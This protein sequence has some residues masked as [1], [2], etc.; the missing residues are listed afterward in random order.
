MSKLRHIIVW[1]SR[2]GHCRGFGIQSPTDYRFVRYVV[3]EHW[4]YYAYDALQTD[5]DDWLTRRMGRLC[6][7]LANHLQPRVIVDRAGFAPW[8]KAGCRRADVVEALPATGV[9]DLAVVTVADSLAALLER[10]TECSVLVVSDLWRDRRQWRTVV[11]DARVSVSFDLYYC[12]IAF[13]DSRRSKHNYKVN[14]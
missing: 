9:Y 10:A 11:A 1:L 4:P 3:N 13:F 12:G 14:F 8:L 2:I 5:A 6:L 7:R